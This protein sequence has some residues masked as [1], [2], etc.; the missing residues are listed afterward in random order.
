MQDRTLTGLLM[1]RSTGDL[2]RSTWGAWFAG[3]SESLFFFFLFSFKYQ[4]S[5]ATSD[6]SFSMPWFVGGGFSSGGMP[7]RACITSGASVGKRALQLASWPSC[8][9]C[10]RV[11]L[12]FARASPAWNVC[13]LDTCSVDLMAHWSFEE[14]TWIVFSANCNAIHYRGVIRWCIVFSKN[15]EGR[16]YLNKKNYREKTF[17]FLWVLPIAYV[18]PLNDMVASLWSVFWQHKINKM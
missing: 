8:G 6:H 1:Q 3:F 16:Y 14:T 10:H 9:L 4:V 2:I 5:W 12:V 7:F 17:F 13:F 18:K 11:Q 15:M